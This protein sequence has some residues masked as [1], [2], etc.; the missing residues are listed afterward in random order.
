MPGAMIGDNLV[1]EETTGGGETGTPMRRSKKKEEGYGLV[2]ERRVKVN[3]IKNQHFIDHQHHFQHYNV[4]M[5]CY[6]LDMVK[7]INI[8]TITLLTKPASASTLKVGT[9][10][11]KTKEYKLPAIHRQF[12]HALPSLEN[13]HYTGILDALPS[14]EN[15]QYTGFLKML[16]YL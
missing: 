9:S 11:G 16:F 4:E 13:F 7:I 3:L 10:D 5:H 8:T 2:K 14:P 12:Q 15:F 1:L 6:W